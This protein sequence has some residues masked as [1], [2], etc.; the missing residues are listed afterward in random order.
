MTQRQLA[1]RSGINNST[2]SRLLSGERN[3]SL[4]TVLKLSRALGG[5]PPDAAD[6]R[7]RAMRHPITHVEHALRADDRLGEQDVRQLMTQYLALRG[8]TE[9]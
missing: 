3:P 4:A 8:P 5:L 7:Q 9:E 1:A 6:W 2:I